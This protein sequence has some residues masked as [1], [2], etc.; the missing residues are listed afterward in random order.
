MKNISLTIQ[1]T[2]SETIIKFAAN[3]VLKSGSFEFNNID[4]AKNSPLAQQ[5][6]HLPFV[7]KVYI[8]ANFIAIERFSIVEW[9]DVQEEVKEQIENFI[10]SGGV[11][12][13]ELAKPQKMPIEVYAESTP[14]PS[15][16]KF[17][18]NTMLVNNDFE[19]K[20]IEE[21]AGSPLAL[22]L[23]DFPFVKELYISENYISITK[24]NSVEWSLITSEVRS[25]IREYLAAGNM[26]VNADVQQEKKH[27]PQEIEHNLDEVS[28]QIMVILD[29]YVRPAVAAD[30]GNILFK[31]Y[32]PNTKIV[33]VILQGACSGCP[34][35]TIT[36]KNGIENMLKQ[37]LPGKIEQVV[38]FNY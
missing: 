22:A 13:T 11:I 10:N 26:V 34:S 21:A 30:G 33:N 18:V 31:S 20:N 27:T 29:E 1:P 17:V 3:E 6:F 12:I 38:A 25:F 23:F 15:V 8:T 5:L 16:L 4:E 28:Q 19:F 9:P 24:A 2:K 32:E 36:L 35:S 37:L 14:N 7:K